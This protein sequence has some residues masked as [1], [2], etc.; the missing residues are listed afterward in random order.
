MGAMQALFGDGHI[1][2]EFLGDRRPI[3]VAGVDRLGAAIGLDAGKEQV[4]AL[5]V[6]RSLQ[7]ERLG[8]GGDLVATRLAAQ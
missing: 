7:S 2:G 4:A 8:V 5:A 6:D 3:G 1:G